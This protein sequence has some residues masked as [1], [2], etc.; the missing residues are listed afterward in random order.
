MPLLAPLS[1]AAGPVNIRTYMVYIRYLT[2]E[3][4][5]LLQIKVEAFY[6]AADPAYEYPY[7]GYDCGTQDEWDDVLSDLLLHWYLYSY[8]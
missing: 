6:D 3:A 1:V 5:V 8:D 7:K 4:I 2:P